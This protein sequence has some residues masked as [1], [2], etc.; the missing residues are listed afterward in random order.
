[1]KFGDWWYRTTPHPCV[2]VHPSGGDKVRGGGWG[3]L[4]QGT[5]QAVP[6]GPE[7]RPVEGAW[8][9]WHQDPLSPNQ[10]FLPNPDETRAGAEGLCQPHDLTG[11]GTPT[12]ECLG[13]LTD[14]DC[15]WLLGYTCSVDVK[16]VFALHMSI[17]SCSLIVIIFLFHEYYFILYIY[18][19]YI[20]IMEVCFAYLIN[21]RFWKADISQ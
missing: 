18:N 17:L 4:V 20:I 12:H 11:D 3:N 21:R 5:C 8:R 19:K 16:S 14:L 1:M 13:Q 15:H 2:I 9:R 10:T 7:P 6:M